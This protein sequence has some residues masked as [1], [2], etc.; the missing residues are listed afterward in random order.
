MFGLNRETKRALELRAE[1][2]AAKLTRRE[3]SKLGLIAGGSAYA[4]G[5]SLRAAIAKE[6]AARPLTAWKDEMPVPPRT[7]VEGYD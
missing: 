7:K 5:A 4:K 3:L 1:L 2:D 6:P